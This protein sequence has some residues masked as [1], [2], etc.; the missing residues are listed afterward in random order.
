M[1]SVIVYKAL[2][3]ATDDNARQLGMTKFGMNIRE[4]FED[5]STANPGTSPSVEEAQEIFRDVFM[6]Y[7]GD[8]GNY[9]VTFESPVVGEE[10]LYVTNAII[11]SAQKLKL[12]LSATKN[13]TTIRRV[14]LKVNIDDLSS[15]ER[16][17][18]ITV[19]HKTSGG[20]FD[21]L[22]E[23]V[24]DVNNLSSGEAFEYMVAATLFNRCR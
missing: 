22:N 4:K 20:G 23:I 19:P 15:I 11:N 3:G 1:S 7:I 12:T 21:Y 5:F 2:S 16:R 10:R 8:P 6:E 24:A 17:M 13:G 14:R 18:N 9:T